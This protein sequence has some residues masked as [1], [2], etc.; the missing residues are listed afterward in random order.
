MEQGVCRHVLATSAFTP[1]QCAELL[2]HAATLG[3]WSPAPVRGAKGARVDPSHRVAE[4]LCFA[5]AEEAAAAGL[6]PWV[7]ALTAVARD[8]DRR[9]L[10]TGLRR[11]EQV[12]VVRYE[13]GGHYA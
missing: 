1:G 13:V 12:Q 7:D 9:H 6:G 11:V 2:A 10:R 5:S 8:V 4:R 3:G